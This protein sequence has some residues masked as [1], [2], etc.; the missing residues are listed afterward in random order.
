MKFYKILLLISGFAFLFVSCG[1]HKGSTCPAYKTDA[2]NEI[3]N[4]QIAFESSVD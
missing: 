2:G 3:S 4:D 1:A